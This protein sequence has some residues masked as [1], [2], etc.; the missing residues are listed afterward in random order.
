MTL[1]DKKFFEHRRREWTAAAEGNLKE[2][3]RCVRDGD[4]VSAAALFLHAF[5]YLMRVEE[6]ARARVAIG[7][8]WDEIEAAIGVIDGAAPPGVVHRDLK[9]EKVIKG[10]RQR[11]L[12]EKGAR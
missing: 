10:A 1:V 6:S 12:F 2:A 7:R 4:H 5:R 9:P 11:E 8:A 3:E